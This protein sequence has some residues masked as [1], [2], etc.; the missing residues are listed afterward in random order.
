MSPARANRIRLIRTRATAGAVAVFIAVWG[1]IGVQLASGN[2][3]ALSKASDSNTSTTATTSTGSDSTTETQS[4]V[5][6]SGQSS[7]SVS[8]VT[9]SQS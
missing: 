6:S 3:P 5:E 2:D 8:P 4:Q 7:T 1:V 9:T